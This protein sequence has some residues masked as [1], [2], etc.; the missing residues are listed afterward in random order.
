M[1]ESLPINVDTATSE[2]PEAVDIDILLRQAADRHPDKLALKDSQRA[3]SWTEFDQRINQMANTLIEKGVQPGDRIALLGRN[4]V[5]YAE[6]IFGSLRA[7]ACFVPLS[8]LVTGESQV[9]MV[10]DSGAKL[11]FVSAEYMDSIKPFRNALDTLTDDGLIQLQGD[12]PIYPNLETFLIEASTVAPSV[13]L[14]PDDG[15]NLIYSSGTTGMPKGILHDRRCRAQENAD[16]QIWFDETTRTLTSTPLYSN[17][18]LFVFFPTLAAGGSV[19]LMEKFSTQ[20]FLE[21]SQREAITN[22]V[23]VPVQYQRLLAD[24]NFKAFDL[25]SYRI[26]FSTSAP[27]HQQVKNDLLA[28]WPAGGLVEIYGMT[29]GGITCLLFAHERPDKLDTVGQPAEDCDL[30][31]IDQEGKILAQGEIG[32]IIGRSP[33]M[34]A[35][36]ANRPQATAEASWYN[37]AGER[38]HKSG[39]IGWLDEEGFVHLL[40]RKKD[41][42]ISGGFNVYAIDLEK[43]LLQH[44]QVADVAVIAVPSEQWGETPLAFVECQNKSKDGLDTEAMRTWANEQLGKAQQISEIRLLTQLPRSPIGKVLKRELRDNLNDKT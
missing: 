23:L 29:E 2:Q 12:D 37:E 42:I 1:T 20:G 31:I 32:E 24:P 11:L 19:I 39:D 25:S 17:T 21:L 30:K 3:L 44:P 6:V 16:L 28:R 18:T 26:K 7:G 27:F 40:D 38:Y 5:E 34:M 14:S 13:T 43:V 9:G 33:K 4:S 10:N 8:T 22:A 35:N 15:F 36:Y 41:M